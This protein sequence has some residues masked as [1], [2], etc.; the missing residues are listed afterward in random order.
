MSIECKL[1]S[2]R[3]DFDELYDIWERQQLGSD[4]TA[5]QS[6]EWNK[7]LFEEWSN[8]R[9]GKLF[10]GIEVYIAKN[11]FSIIIM[12]C[13]V[14]KKSSYIKGGIGRRKG[15]YLLGDGSYSDYLSPIYNFFF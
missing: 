14:Q 9:W 13:I 15:I 7:C 3:K 6:I 8:D 2:N 10:S 11:E 1:I 4:M 5:F 12:P